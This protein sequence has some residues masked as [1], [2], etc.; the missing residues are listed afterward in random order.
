MSVHGCCSTQSCFF[1]SFYFFSV[2]PQSGGFNSVLLLCLDVLLL[3]LIDHSGWKKKKNKYS[4][5][6]AGKSEGIGWPCD[7]C[8]QISRD[9]KC[10]TR[11]SETVRHTRI[12]SHLKW[13]QTPNVFQ[14][15]SGKKNMKGIFSSVQ[16]AWTASKLSY[17]RM[18]K[19]INM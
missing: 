10:L 5:A 2:W 8:C 17:I 19:Y 11:G 15:T 7:T 4:A 13:S 14:C 3:H 12:V 18:A 9:G 1:L 6:P 16:S